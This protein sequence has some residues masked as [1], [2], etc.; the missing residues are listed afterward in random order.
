MQPLGIGIIGCGTISGAYLTALRGFPEL[1][2]R[3]VADLDEARAETRAAEFGTRAV[4]VAALLADPSIDLVINLTVPKAHAAVGMQVLDAGKH[5]YAEKPLALTFEEGRRLVAVA[6]EHGLRIGSAPDTFLGGA[7]QTCRALID[8]G[9][10]GRPV[11]GTAYF[12][13]PGHERWHPNPAFYYDEGG[14]P[15]LDM[16]PYYITQLVNLLGPVA[17]VAGFA[18][19]LRATRPIL[20]DP[21]RRTS[22]PVAVDTHVMGLLAFESGAI[23]QIGMSFDVEDHRHAPLEVY[24]TDGVLLNPDPNLFGGRVELR[25]AGGDWT[26]VSVT[27]P[28][29]DGNFRSLGAADLARAIAVGEPHRAGGALAL[30][31]LEVM[32]AIHRAS[33]ERRVLRLST[34]T[35]RPAP[36]PA[37]CP[38][39]VSPSP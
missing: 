30:H 25:T 33:D 29:A 17:E 26:D 39:S 15:M 28:W 9:R 7:H 31:V 3:A 5:L 35:E 1:A 19:R 22:M 21:L 34:S 18:S 12:M 11:G 10:I 14:G 36:L 38:S 37:S 13:C 16:G 27:R 20:S 6:E 2:T 4:S 32:L 24:G 23:V 8:D